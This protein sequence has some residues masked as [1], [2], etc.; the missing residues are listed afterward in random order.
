[1]ETRILK[2]GQKRTIYVDPFTEKV[3]EGKAMLVKKVSDSVRSEYWKVRFIS[4]GMTVQ[5]Q[6]KIN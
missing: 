6:I 4:D 3:A 5:R 2:K 1:M